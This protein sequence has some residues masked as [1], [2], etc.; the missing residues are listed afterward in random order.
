MLGPLDM[1]SLTVFLM[2]YFVRRSAFA[3]QSFMLSLDCP[4]KDVPYHNS[5]T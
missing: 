1:L 4:I 3:G 5:V 2:Q